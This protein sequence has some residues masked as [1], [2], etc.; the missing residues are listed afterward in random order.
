MTYT[1]QA[2]LLPIDSDTLKSQLSAGDWD[3]LTGLTAEEMGL[4]VNEATVGAYRK[5][6]HALVLEIKRLE[7]LKKRV[8]AAR[9]VLHRAVNG[10][11]G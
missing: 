2:D 6:D 8:I 4:W 5:L 3:V 7:D 1:E 10:H 9:S 11:N